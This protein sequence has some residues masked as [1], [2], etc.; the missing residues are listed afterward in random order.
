VR[1]DLPSAAPRVVLREQLGDRNARVLGVGDVRVAVR[2][3]ELH[4]LDA[5]VPLE[6]ARQWL[7]LEAL[8]DVERDEGGE[9][10]TIGRK[11]RDFGA[12]V[13]RPDRLGPGG[14]VPGEIFLREAAVLGLRRRNDRVGDA[15][16]VERVRPALGDL[17]E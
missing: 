2:E 11:L 13:G 5:S 14:A 1:S 6:G 10:L 16:L 9:S 7:R 15:P 17:R 8:E 4:G 12:A 3:R